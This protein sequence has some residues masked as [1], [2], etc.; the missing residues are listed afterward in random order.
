MLF[1]KPAQKK[2]FGT[3]LA[4]PQAPASNGHI[5]ILLKELMVTIT[6]LR[7]VLL[8]ENDALAHSNSRAFLAIQDEKVAVARKYEGLMTELLSRDDIKNADPQIKKQ[9]LSL[10]QGFTDVM[11]DN[12]TRLERMK[13]AT[14]KL[15]ERIM[16]SARK[17]AEGMTQFAY[18]A[19]GTMQKGT[20]ATIGLS[21]QA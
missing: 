10:E 1:N 5:N 18:G 4:A 7:D 20:K 8:K 16:K 12:M 11:K 13:G 17:S 6:A 9:L 3:K 14:E 2:T 21:E 15:G 19:A